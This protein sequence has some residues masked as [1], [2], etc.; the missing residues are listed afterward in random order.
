MLYHYLRS[1][2]LMMVAGMDHGYEGGLAM[3]WGDEPW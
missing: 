3:G 1:E 2:M